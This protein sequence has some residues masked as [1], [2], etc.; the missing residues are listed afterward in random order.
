MQDL[1][2]LTGGRVISKATG[3]TLQQVR[4]EDLVRDPEPVV[5]RIL[6]FLGEPFDLSVI[7]FR[8][9][10]E[11]GKTPLLQQ[12]LQP[13]NLEKWRKALSRW[14]LWLFEGAAGTLLYVNGYPL[15][16][17]ARPTPLPLR[18]LA[19]VHNVWAKNFLPLLRTWQNLR[20]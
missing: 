8:K 10:K 12:D 9:S 18:I 3:D 7:H 11:P 16:T 6:D 17:R 1:A 4:Y 19:R 13:A 15:V 14:Q 20:F 2:I 5:H